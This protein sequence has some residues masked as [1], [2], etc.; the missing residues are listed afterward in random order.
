[1]W[2]TRYGIKRYIGK[3]QNW[4]LFLNYELERAE[5]LNNEFIQG[6][7]VNLWGEVINESDSNHAPKTPRNDICHL[8]KNTIE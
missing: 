8:A 5:M 7:F 3:T 6:E 4:N 2:S 1:M